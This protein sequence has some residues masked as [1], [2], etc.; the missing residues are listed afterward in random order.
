MLDRAFMCSCAVEVSP[1]P[2]VSAQ[3]EGEK[4]GGSRER[5][6]T[7]ARPE[8]QSGLRAHIFIS[9]EL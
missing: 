6:V 1:T 5:I 2:G 3:V 9:L 4:G 7:R 8:I